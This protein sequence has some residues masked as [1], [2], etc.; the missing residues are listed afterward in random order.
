MQLLTLYH[1]IYRAIIICIVMLSTFPGQLGVGDHKSYATPRKV[2]LPAG[3]TPSSV[4]CGSDCSIIITSSGQLLASGH[5]KYV[6]GG[7]AEQI[8][9]EE[10]AY[11]SQYDH[12]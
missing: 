6:C 1:L 12:S 9:H 10:C 11:N 8:V 2:K 3:H 7:E 4:S 5:N